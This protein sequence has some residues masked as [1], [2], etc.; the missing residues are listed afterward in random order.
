MASDPE[1]DY[2]ADSVSTTTA[3]PAALPSTITRAEAATPTEL[4]VE[5]EKYGLAKP[6]RV[7]IRG[8]VARGKD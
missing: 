8:K 7:V 3:A 6:R 1:S 2:I 5:I 4:K